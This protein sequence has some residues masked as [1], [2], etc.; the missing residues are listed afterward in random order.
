ML[1]LAMIKL[2]AWRRARIL[3]RYPLPDRSWRRV[4]ARLRVLD[5][6]SAEE[7]SR[8]RDWTTLFVHEKS[9]VAARGLRLSETM[10]LS[11]GAQACL[12][13]LNL[14]IDYFREI[15]EIVL[16]PESFLVPRE[17]HDEAGVV[18]SSRHVLAGESWEQGPVILSWADARPG[19]YP[20]GAGTNVVIHEFAHKLD[21]LT[22]AANGMPPLHS[23]MDSAVWTRVFRRAYEEFNQQVTRGHETA[24]D[25]YAAEAPGEFFA[26]LSE[27]FFELPHVVEET[28]PAVYGELGRFY[29]QDPASRRR[30]GPD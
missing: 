27:V 26:V 17:E 10:Q 11:I 13:I 29:R 28:F 12:L 22:G 15:V 19:A 9:F 23:D 21:M 24:I 20:F 18:H 14:D 16:Y 8:L 4:V 5:A 6:L 1:G 2:K 25:P 30:A 7:L 3:R